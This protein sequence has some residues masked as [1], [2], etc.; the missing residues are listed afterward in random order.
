M[1]RVSWRRRLAHAITD[2]VLTPE[3]RRAVET[4][5][6]DDAGHGWDRFGMSSAGI[7]VALSTLR[8]LYDFYFRVESHGAHH[9]PASGPTIVAANHS[10]TLPL[11]GLML[12]TDV[13][14]NSNPARVPRPIADYFVPAL[15]FVNIL[16]SRGGMISGSRGNVHAALEAGELLLV[17]PEGV[18]GIGKSWSERYRLQ[19]WTVGHAELALRHRAKVVPVAIIGAEEALPQAAKIRL[20]AFG[21]P[22]LPIPATPVPLPTRFRIHYGAPIDLSADFGPEAA[23]D[24]AALTEAAARVHDA[25]EGL[26]ATGLEEREA[27][28]R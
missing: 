22:Y 17:F 14:L 25:V 13:L 23:R 18:Q 6:V 2:R 9:I 12:W 11:D 3:Q 16:F 10:G 7:G 26:I 21:I 24:P 27:V 28:F 1:A 4:I 8:H 20:R 15:P 19:R 5:A